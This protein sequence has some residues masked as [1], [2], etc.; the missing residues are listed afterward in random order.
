[1]E[2]EEAI[3]LLREMQD[4]CKTKKTYKDDKAEAKAEAIEVVLKELKDSEETDIK[5]YKR[6]NIQDKVIDEMAGMINTRDFGDICK[7][8]GK[9]KNCSNYIKEGLCE[10]CIKEYF[11]KKVE[12]QE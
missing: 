6:L 4:N 3:K 11:Y 2:L 9:Y 7:Q 12:E 10:K 5:L 1:M 8:F